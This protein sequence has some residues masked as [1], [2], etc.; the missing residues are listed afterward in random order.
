MRGKNIGLTGF[1]SP[2]HL[3]IP[4]GKAAPQAPASSKLPFPA[5]Q[6]PLTARSQFWSLL[7]GPFHRALAGLPC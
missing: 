3:R 7:L 5:P 6:L 4:R 2:Q 1:L